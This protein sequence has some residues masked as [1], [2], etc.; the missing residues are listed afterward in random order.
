M[1]ASTVLLLATAM[2]LPAVP[3]LAQSVESL[4]GYFAIEELGIFAAG[5]LEV[6]IDL[7][8]AM[9][10]IVAAAAANEDPQFSAAMER[11]Q[12]IRV[13][14]G[15]IGGRDA[16]GV[17]AAID[18]AVKKLEG[19]GW[20]RTVTVRDEEESVNVLALE[21]GELLRGLS[22]LVD[23]GEGEVVLVNI[24]GDMDPEV[25]GSL[26]SNIDQ[27]EGLREGLEERPAAP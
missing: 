6:D 21:S 13:Q 18:S 8:G 20:Y 27:L 12:R 25:I 10:K 16:S 24:A 17:R 9:A 2:L 26:I 22:V 23:D 5:E 3:G 14:V 15:S 11:I 1:R 4:P 7:R 19:S